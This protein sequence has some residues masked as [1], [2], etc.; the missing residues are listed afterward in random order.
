MKLISVSKNAIFLILIA[1][2]L[3]CQKYHHEREPKEFKLT[4]SPQETATFKFWMVIY[5]GLFSLERINDL[6]AN[7]VKLR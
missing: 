1:L 5:E 6:F 7:Y 2:L 4:L 3:V